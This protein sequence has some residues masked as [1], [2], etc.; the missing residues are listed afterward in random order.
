MRKKSFNISL[1]L[2]II[3]IFLFLSNT[4]SVLSETNCET[5]SNDLSQL[6]YNYVNS[7]PFENFGF[8]LMEKFN[9]KSNSWEFFKENGNFLV[10]RIYDSKLLKNF[11]SKSKKF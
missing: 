4:N 9:Q 10:G 11:K 3:V 6:N 5:F 1:K 2:K 8:D 7:V